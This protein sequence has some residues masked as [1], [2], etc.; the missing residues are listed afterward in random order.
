MLNEPS[1]ESRSHLP[2]T[3]DV[4]GGTLSD[5]VISG[6]LI[7]TDKYT[8]RVQEVNSGRGNLT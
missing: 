7:S 5:G 8:H 2:G 3:P 1:S 6:L 4:F